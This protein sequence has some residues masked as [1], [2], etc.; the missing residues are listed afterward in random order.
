MPPKDGEKGRKGSKEPN[1]LQKPPE[2]PLTEVTRE[3]YLIQI[4]DL[5]SRLARYQRRWDELVVEEKLFRLEFE[6][7]ANNKKEIVAFLKRTLNQRVDEITDLN[8]QLQ[9][10]QLSKEAEKDAFEA[11]LAQVR[12]EFQET[13]DQLTSENM[14][15]GGKLAA[16]DDFRLQKEELMAQFA[17]LEEQLKKQELEYKEHIYHLEKKA[18]LDKDNLKKEIIQ[19]V[20]TV[21]SEF[22]KIS[23]SQMA[24]TTKRA[25]RENMRVTLQL[26][27]VSSRSLALMQE[28]EQLH[29]TAQEMRKEL[30]LLQHMEKAMA[31]D[32]LGNKKMI[33]L[34]SEKCREQQQGVEEAHQLRKELGSLKVAFERLQSTNQALSGLPS[35]PPPPGVQEGGEA[36]GGR[37]G[38]A[39]GGGTAP[40]PGAG[41]GTEAEAE[42]G[43][44]VS[45]GH[46]LP[47]RHPVGAAARGGWPLR[48]AVPAAAQ[49]AAATPA[50]PAEQDRGRPTARPRI[51]APAGRR[52]PGAEPSPVPAGAPAPAAEQ[53]GALQARGPGT[54]PPPAAPPPQP[55]RHRSA[56]TDQPAWSPP[57]FR[58]LPELCSSPQEGSK[59]GQAACTPT[60]PPVGKGHIYPSKDIGG[61][62][63]ES[64]P[65]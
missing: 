41:W 23:S 61:R 52:A 21:A 62:A 43:A 19:R 8:E 31:K 11:Q 15:L 10:L 51:C 26:A 40:E 58:R 47:Q 3:F 16:L 32:G 5:E 60:A 39:E 2:E 64:S 49:R 33:Q 46:L 25:I 30:V 20:N 29:C 27:N 57:G 63:T 36:A 4:R 56:L 42:P 48:R 14:V 24:E 54:H 44:G 50:V 59:A 53:S 55:P 12:H 37:G 6:Q 13:K 28:N 34:L 18:V 35:L 9:G 1:P 38:A 22:R 17:L 65:A 45:P 7:L